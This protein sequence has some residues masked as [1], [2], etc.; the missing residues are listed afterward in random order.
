LFASL[1]EKG[2]E[3][4]RGLWREENREKIRKIF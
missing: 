2:G 4:R 1:E 3:G